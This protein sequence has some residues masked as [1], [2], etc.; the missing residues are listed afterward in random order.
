[1][2]IMYG[3]IRIYAAA[4]TSVNVVSELG[5]TKT[6][7]IPTGATFV[8]VPLLGLEQYAISAN[9]ITRTVLLNYNDFVEVTL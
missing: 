3:K 6:V 4:E 2:A 1:M 7:T 8:D 9:G 5:V